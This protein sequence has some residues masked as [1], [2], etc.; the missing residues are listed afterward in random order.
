MAYQPIPPC[1][2][3]LF[4]LM[5]KKALLLADNLL[6]KTHVHTLPIQL[7]H[8]APH[9]CGIKILTYKQGEKRLNIPDTTIES[10]SAS[11]PYMVFTEGKRPFP[12]RKNAVF[13]LFSIILNRKEILGIIPV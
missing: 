4:P 12:L 2:K 11:M 6:Q 10:L 3:A 13:I 5:E 7:H 9:L 1:V 8:L